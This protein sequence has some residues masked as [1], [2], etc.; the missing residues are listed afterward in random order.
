MSDAGGGDALSVIMSSFDGCR[1]G[2][3]WLVVGGEQEALDVEMAI[4]W[5]MAPA[6]AAA[7]ISLARIM[8]CACTGVVASSALNVCCTWARSCES[9]W[10]KPGT[11]SKPR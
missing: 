1:C 7:W 8:P 11:W 10:L 2:R 6:A 4:G 3:K 5:C 9:S